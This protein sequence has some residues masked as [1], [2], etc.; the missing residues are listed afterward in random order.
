MGMIFLLLLICSLSRAQ[1]ETESVNEMM[2]HVRQTELLESDTGSLS[3]Q[4]PTCSQEIN[5]VLREMTGSLAGLKVQVGYLE[6]DNEAKTRELEL[7]KNEL[8]KI[9]QQFQA[10]VE[11]VT[12]VKALANSTEHQVEVLWKE[13]K[14][15]VIKVR[16]L[17]QQYQAKRVAFSA[18]VFTGGAQG[19]VGPFNTDTV[20][21]FRHVATNTGNAYN[22][23]TG[24][25][26][27]PVRG[28]YHFEF[29]LHGHGHASHPT[30][31][32]LVKNGQQIF[33]A[34]EWQS[35]GSV[36]PANGV[37]LHLESGDVV[38]ARLWRN[39]RIYDTVNHHTTFSGHL[40]FLL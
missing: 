18:S 37:N 31:A 20:L 4:P 14:E 24:I 12:T 28:V 2:S 3:N 32:T 15:Q 9:K 35:S 27:A 23:H 16:R 22:P 19:Y 39:A 6:R 36:N 8:E 7:L 26:S 11:E 13:G 10:Q 38:F 21:I 17:E 1:L 29:Y 5:S 34:F 25:F 33:T 30:A 40:L